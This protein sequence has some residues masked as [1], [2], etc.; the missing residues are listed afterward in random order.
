DQDV[1]RLDAVVVERPAGQGQEA[2]AG[3]AAADDAVEGAERGSGRDRSHR[4]QGHRDRRQD[5]VALHAPTSSTTRPHSASRLVKTSETTEGR[6]PYRSPFKYYVNF[7]GFYGDCGGKVNHWLS[8]IGWNGLWS[9]PQPFQ[10]G[11]HQPG[12]ILQVVPAF[13]QGEDAAAADL[14]G[15][16]GA[17]FAPAAETFLGHPHAA[18]R[19]VLPGV[20]AGREDQDVGGEAAQRRQDLALDR[21]R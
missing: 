5:D 4:Q 16:P 3:V 14:G 15:E 12:E 2:G 20:E 17:P 18:Q 8:S 7:R 1:H 6:G 11:L 19:V 13:E 21:L 10:V 9:S